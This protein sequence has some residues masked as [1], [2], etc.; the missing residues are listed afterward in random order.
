MNIE[1]LKVKTLKRHPVHEKLNLERTQ[2]ELATHGESIIKYGRQNPLIFQLIEVDG[3]MIPHVIDGWSSVQVA[4]HNNI[5]TLPGIA[6]SECSEDELP[7]LIIE[8]QSGFHRDPE[9]DYKRF[10]YLFQHYSRGKGFRSDLN[11]EL[12]TWSYE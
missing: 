6:V 9:E 3:K 5:E 11:D 4:L 1:Q 8:I 2:E 12:N 7:D 10:E